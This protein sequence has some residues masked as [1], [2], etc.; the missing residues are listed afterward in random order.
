M[1]KRRSRRV[2]LVAAV[3]VTFS[4]MV[5]GL[6]VLPHTAA[7]DWIVYREV[8]STCGF[9]EAWE[10][11][12]LSLERRGW[13]RHGPPHIHRIHDYRGELLVVSHA[14]AV[15]WMQFDDSVFI[16]DRPHHH[17]WVRM[18]SSGRVIAQPGYD[19]V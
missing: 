19:A 2:V 5:V 7:W 12:T 8:P 10:L 15:T 16:E 9:P 18:D 6:R 1:P 14:R 3:V 11:R 17:V 13:I 4:A